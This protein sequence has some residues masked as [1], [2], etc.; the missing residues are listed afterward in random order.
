MGPEIDDIVKLIDENKTRKTYIDP[1][2]K[3]IGWFKKYIKEEVN[4][5][6]SDFI[7]RDYVFFDGVVE[8][9]VD[10]FIDY[11]LLD[12]DNTTLAIIEAKHFSK[13]EKSPTMEIGDSG[14]KI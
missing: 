9:Y 1:T 12:E 13:N 2:L 6:K 14:D 11:V 3:E 4:S 7:N 10:R 8:K 5:V